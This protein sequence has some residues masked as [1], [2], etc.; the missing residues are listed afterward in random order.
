MRQFLLI[1]RSHIN[2]TIIKDQSTL[3]NEAVLVVSF[4]DVTPLVDSSASAL[5][6]AVKPLTQINFALVGED[7][8]V[9][10]GAQLLLQVE[11]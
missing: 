9:L 10:A 4:P 3:Y 5:T 11:I 8:M 2:T 7:F 1:K 6:D